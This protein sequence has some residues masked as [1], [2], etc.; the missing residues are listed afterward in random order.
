MLQC[1]MFNIF[2]NNY[3]IWLEHLAKFREMF[4]KIW[5]KFNENDKNMQKF[6][7]KICETV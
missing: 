1:S 6:A 3:Y 4:M 7:E 2:Y 5:A